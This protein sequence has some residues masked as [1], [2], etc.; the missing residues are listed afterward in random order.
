MKFAHICSRWLLFLVVA[1]LPAAG[2][3]AAA[4][5]ENDP[6]DGAIRLA[7][8]N[9]PNRQFAEGVVTT[10][11]MEF[12]AD[13]TYSQPEEYLD[14]LE[15]IP[16]LDWTPNSLATTRTL[17]AMASRVVYRRDIWGLEFAFKP[18][19]MM[20]VDLPQPSGRLQRK[21]IW[22][23]VYKVTNRGNPLRRVPIKDEFGNIR[24]EVQQIDGLPAAPVRF[25]PR[26]VLHGT[27]V[28]KQYL[29]RVLPAAAQQ[30][31]QRETGGSKLYNSV[32]ISRFDIPVTTD[33]QDNS[34]WGVV[35]WEDVDPE[36]D[37]FSIYVEGL[38]NAFR[39]KDGE[40]FD[41]DAPPLA[42]R[43]FLQK[44]L[45]LNFWRP[46]DHLDEHEGEIRFGV[47]GEVDH[48]WVY[49]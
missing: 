45:K 47:P 36:I 44:A 42:Y 32:E 24:Y 4:P 11:P 9:P 6:R 28:D 49:R 27:D 7:Q 23:M 40:T 20:E 39:W 15:G 34:V 46:G 16:N 8:A 26:F 1:A 10:I 33:E 19:R 37:Y 31:A 14:I 29:D 2:A 3:Q 13:D 18:V 22:Y 43:S 21:R 25:Y 17:Q 48:E 35:T 12:S 38:T 30:I 41:P 5:E